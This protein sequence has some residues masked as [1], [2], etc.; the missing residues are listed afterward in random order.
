MPREDDE[1][2]LVEK[3]AIWGDMLEEILRDNGI[4]HYYVP[5]LGA[6]LSM[7]IGRYRDSY[8]FFVPYAFLQSARD[9]V[10]G[11]FAPVREEPTP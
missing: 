2:F 7:K 10:D 9:I 8:R 1:C 5:M 11:V 3:E 6:G 4:P